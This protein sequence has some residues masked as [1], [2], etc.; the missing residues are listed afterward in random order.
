MQL[1]AISDV[2]IFGAFW[3]NF[4]IF[5]NSGQLKTNKK[6]LKFELTSDTSNEVCPSANCLIIV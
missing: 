1:N 3:K 4:F 6:I 5:H 2:M